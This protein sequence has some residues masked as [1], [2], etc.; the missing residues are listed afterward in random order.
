MVCT[1]ATGGE[2]EIYLSIHYDV[3][4]IARAQ[5]IKDKAQ[6]QFRKS[7]ITLVLLLNI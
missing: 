6:I 4:C 1:L 2:Y 7:H 5:T 3:H